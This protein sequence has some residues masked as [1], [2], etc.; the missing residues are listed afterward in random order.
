M[1]DQRS[2]KRITD[3]SVG[4]WKPFRCIGGHLPRLHVAH[5]TQR[6]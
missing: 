6:Q 5:Q 1:F 4:L 2:C 3:R